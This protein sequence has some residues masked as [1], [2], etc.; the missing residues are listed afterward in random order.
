MVLDPQ[1]LVE[2]F[3]C[4]VIKLLSTI[5]D[6]DFRDLKATDN[7]FQTK[8]RTFFSVTMAKGSTSTHL[9]K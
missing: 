5:G 9:I 6:K 7:A 8:F 2:I 3:E 1:L 4:F